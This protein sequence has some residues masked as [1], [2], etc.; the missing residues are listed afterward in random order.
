M[1][2]VWLA[3]HTTLKSEV[4]VKLIDSELGKAEQPRARFLREAQ[5]AARIKSAHVTQT[6]DYGVGD[7]GEPYI[8]ME[9]LIGETLRDRLNARGRLPSVETARIVSHVARAL[10]RAHEAGLVHRDLK[11]ENIFIVREVDDEVIKVLDFGVAKAAD[12]LSDSSIDPTRTGAMLG[13]PFYM[14][15][16]QAQGLKTVDARADVWAMGVVVFECLTGTLPFS[17]EALGP[18]IAKIIAGPLPVPSAVAPDAGLPP[19][20]DAWMARALARDPG[21]RFASA[22]ELAEGFMIASGST[23]SFQR[24]DRPLRGLPSEV[25]VPPAP[26]SVPDP[27]AATAL[28]TPNSVAPAVVVASV[29]APSRAPWIVAVVVLSGLV[30]LLGLML[31][32]RR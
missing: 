27:L 23:D 32:L 9:Y 5:L 20:V 1:G 13:T 4:A 6:Y 15:P 2:S 19:S 11:P 7:D 3:E 28:D 25:V 14:S 17:A 18:L 29:A 12:A 21:A 10:T 30:V 16:E 22:R 26:R 31:A 8:A 24:S